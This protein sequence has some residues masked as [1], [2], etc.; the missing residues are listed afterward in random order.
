MASTSVSLGEHFEG[1]I[2]EQVETGRYKSASDVMRAALRL[3][4][5]QEERRAALKQ[6]IAEGEASGYP[7]TFDAESFR[8]RMRSKHRVGE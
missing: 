4:E 1:F 5:E 2:A 7:A 3:L 8:A 6:A